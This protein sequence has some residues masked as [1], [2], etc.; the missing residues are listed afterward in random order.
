MFKNEILGSPN[1]GAIEIYKIIK[2]SME[3][4]ANE[5]L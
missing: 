2:A 4:R 5:I 3:K 1:I